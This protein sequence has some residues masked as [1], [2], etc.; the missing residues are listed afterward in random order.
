[1]TA[2]IHLYV[3]MYSMRKTNGSFPFCSVCSHLFSPFL[4]S[5]NLTT[6]KMLASPSSSTQTTGSTESTFSYSLP[7]DVA[8]INY[9]RLYYS[10]LATIGRQLLCR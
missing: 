4:V 3:Y 7:I 10:K 9:E 8:E 5:R 6:C 2:G 1:M